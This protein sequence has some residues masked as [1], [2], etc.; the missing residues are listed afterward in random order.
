MQNI[1]LSRLSHFDIS[2]C[3]I[4]KQSNGSEFITVNPDQFIGIRFCTNDKC[5]TLAKSFLDSQIIPQEILQNTYGENLNIKRQ[6]GEIENEWLIYGNAYQDPI[7]NILW[8]RVCDK[9]YTKVK[10]IPLQDLEKL[11]QPL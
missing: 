6:S 7:T 5:K 3:D 2:N 11:N 8:V 4:C 9:D 1:K 10:Q